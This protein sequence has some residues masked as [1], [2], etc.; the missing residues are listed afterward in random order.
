LHGRLAGRNAICTVQ[1]DVG[2]SGQPSTDYARVILERMEPD[3]VYRPQDL[4]AFAPELGVERLRAVMHEL[5][6]G[7]E[8]ERAGDAGW[9]RV[10]SRPPHRRDSPSSGA[11]EHVRPDE[12]FDHAAFAEFF[13]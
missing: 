6:I 9:R 2:I 11:V 7:R 5:W 10:R 12:L 1:P 4:L 8:V 13:K 3:S